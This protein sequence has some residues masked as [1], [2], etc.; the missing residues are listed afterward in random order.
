MNPLLIHPTP[1]VAAAALLRQR[2]PAILPRVVSE[3]TADRQVSEGIEMGHRLTSYLERRVPLWV[4]A[5][6]ADDVER[7]AAIGR[8]LRT[9]VESAEHIP[10][11]ILLGTIA[12]GY[13]FIESEIREHASEYGFSPDA[14]WAEMDLLRRTV[15]EM[16]RR[17]GDGESVA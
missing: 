13:R 8:L 3:A 11:V 12:I 10:P 2:G 16:R 17:L 9:D 4:Q 6:E 5:L 1:R 7:G 15:A 14:L